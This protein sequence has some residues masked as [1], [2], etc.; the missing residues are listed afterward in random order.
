MHVREL[1]C[2]NGIQ[3]LRIVATYLILL[4]SIIQHCQNY[5]IVFLLRGSQPFHGADGAKSL[6][7]IVD[8]IGNDIPA[9]WLWMLLLLL[10]RKTTQLSRSFK[11]QITSVLVE[12]FKVLNSVWIEVIHQQKAQTL[13][14]HIH[15]F[16]YWYILNLN[17][18]F[19]KYF[20][21]QCQ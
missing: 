18:Q 3:L 2:F 11:V 6:W 9:A 1:V 4:L 21:S 20:W 8:L 17:K 12:R 7:S 10:L 15:P 5:R 16:D 14:L 19:F 13:S